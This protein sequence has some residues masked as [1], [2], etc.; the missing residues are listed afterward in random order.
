MTNE[1]TCDYF[2]SDHCRVEFVFVFCMHSCTYD[3]LDVAFG[4]PQVAAFYGTIFISEFAV[5]F[6]LTGTVWCGTLTFHSMV[7]AVH[8]VFDVLI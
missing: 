2:S 5:A 4:V 7:A 3:V 8:S 6:A 1:F